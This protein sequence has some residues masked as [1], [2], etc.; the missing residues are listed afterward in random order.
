MVAGGQGGR[1]ALSAAALLGFSTVL[2]VGLMLLFQAQLGVGLPLAAG[3]CIYVAASDLIPEINQ[4]PG[5]RFALVVFVGVGLLLALHYW[6]E[7]G[8]RISR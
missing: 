5:I 7:P 2:G 3:V 8:G 4:Q 1:A 6:L